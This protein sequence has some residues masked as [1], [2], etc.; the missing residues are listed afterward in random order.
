MMES[1][2]R[3]EARSGHA[4]RIVLPFHCTSIPDI[5]C[6]LLLNGRVAATFCR[7]LQ[8]MSS[9][10]FFIDANG[11]TLAAARATIYHHPIHTGGA[12]MQPKTRAVIALDALGLAV[13][14]A[15]FV[16]WCVRT[17]GLTAAGGIAAGCSA[18]LFA[19]VGL[20][21]VPAWVRFWQRG[22]R[23]A[24]RPGAGAGAH[25]R[26]Y[27]RRAGSRSILRC[28]CSHGASA[29]SPDSRRRS[30]RRSNSGAASTAGTI[31]TS[32]A[33]ATSPP[34]TP[35]AS[36]SSCFCRVTRLRCAR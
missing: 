8:T 6:A 24:R 1:R 16:L 30:R 18:A 2:G 29:P 11:C 27:F 34:V 32:R 4:S 22:G 36:C 31:S 15:I 35:T 7:S 5:V 23:R 12:A 26:A 25:G 19:A 21:F 9:F 13:L 3:C 33:T 14:A 17:P 28:S 10:L 20:R